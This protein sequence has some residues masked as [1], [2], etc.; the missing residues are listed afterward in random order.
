LPVTYAGTLDYT[1]QNTPDEY[2]VDEG[3]RHYHYDQNGGPDV[4]S[5]YLPFG[6]K[7]AEP[8]RNDEGRFIYFFDNS[9]F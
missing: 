1:R 2:K 8:E 5:N 6:Q 9:H 7:K 3:Q 4:P